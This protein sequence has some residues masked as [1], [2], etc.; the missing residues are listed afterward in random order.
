MNQ[1]LPAFATV[2]DMWPQR[3]S[4]VLLVDLYVPHTPVDLVIAVASLD[5]VDPE[6][7]RSFAVEAVQPALEHLQ[8]TIGDVVAFDVVAVLELPE[9][10]GIGMPVFRKRKRWVS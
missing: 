4:A 6:H 10:M 9:G 7:C 5:D 1:Y 3:D 8:T 2:V